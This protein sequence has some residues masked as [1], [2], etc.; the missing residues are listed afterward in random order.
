M[1]HENYLC[2]K[3]MCICPIC[4]GLLAEPTIVRHCGHYFCRFC[5][6]RKLKNRKR[7]PT[8]NK[9]LV[10]NDQYLKRDYALQRVLYI[11][12]ND[13][14]KRNIKD[15][16]RKLIQK[17]KNNVIQEDVDIRL[18]VNVKMNCNEM[19]KY[20]R[21]LECPAKLPIATLKKFLVARTGLN[22]THEIDLTFLG[23][24]LSSSETLIDVLYSLNF[25]KS[26]CVYEID[27]VI[28]NPKG[29]VAVATNL[30]RNLI[31]H[32][33]D[34]DG[35]IK[36]RIDNGNHSATMNSGPETDVEWARERQKPLN[37]FVY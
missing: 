2:S 35:G 31:D 36:R 11:L 4:T 12:F 16:I 21:F 24:L 34:D 19:T 6:L 10:Q 32:F 1:S 7:C 26:D 23:C 28:K 8:C 37:F 17:G 29:I 15:R 22:E 25:T 3:S 27:A 14:T 20:Q 5:L 9:R 33:D 13:A 30:K 18:V